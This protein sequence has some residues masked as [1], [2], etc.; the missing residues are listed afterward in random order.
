MKKLFLAPAMAFFMSFGGVAH[1]QAVDA[2]QP[3]ALIKTVTSQVMDAA[4]SDSAIQ[5][6]DVGRIT[7]LVNQKILPYSDFSRTTQ[8]TM[9]RYWRQATPQQREQITQ[10]FKTLLIRTYSGAISQIRNQTIQYLPFRG[11]A[12]ADDAVVRTQVNNN[13][14]LVELDYRLRKTAQGWRVYDIN[15][16]GA[17]LIQ[18]YQQQFSQ[19]IQ[20]NG[21]DGLIRFLTTRN[22]QLANGNG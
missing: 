8:L 19:Q 6:G 20:Q 17:W 7:Q 9:G 11:E 2:S 18:A 22:Q 13:G 4:K 10:Q 1:A 14:Q 12:N 15:V 21:I 5:Q 3:D 16:L